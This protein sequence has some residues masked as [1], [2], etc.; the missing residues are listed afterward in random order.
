MIKIIVEHKVRDFEAWKPV[1]ESSLDLVASHGGSNMEVGLLHGTNNNVYVTGDFT[2]EKDFKTFFGTEEMK[3]KMK[4][5]GV[6]SEPKV[7]ILNEVS[8]G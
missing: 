2:S 4:E 7:T 5:S 3:N 8:R 6:I 1:Y